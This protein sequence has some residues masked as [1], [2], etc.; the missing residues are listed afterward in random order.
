MLLTQD[1]PAQDGRWGKSVWQSYINSPFYTH[2]YTYNS[3]ILNI[4][5]HELVAHA[6]SP[7]ERQAVERI[8]GTVVCMYA[9]LHPF[10]YVYKLIIHILILY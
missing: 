1:R 6:A 7:C 8:G 10:T 4:Q 5:Y 2:V 3:I 9:N